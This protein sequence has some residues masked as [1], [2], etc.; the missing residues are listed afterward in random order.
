MGAPKPPKKTR[1]EKEALQSQTDMLN[2]Q[3]DLMQQ[4][5]QQQQLL[6]PILYK[7]AGL[8]PIYG[9]GVSQDTGL[10]FK[11]GEWVQVRPNT[12]GQASGEITGFED[13]GPTPEEQAYS[14]LLG[15]QVKGAKYAE[16][17][18]PLQLRQQ[19]YD[20]VLDE[21]GMPTAIN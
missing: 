8:K 6:A 11:N 1:E 4:Q 15:M 21:K 18:G 13:L 16:A 10:E 19:G 17:L 12:V 5:Q 9:G 2:Y 7:Q 14:D 20:V 3:R